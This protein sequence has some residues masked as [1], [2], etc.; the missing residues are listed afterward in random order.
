MKTKAKA[1]CR[2]V[3]VRQAKTVK[4][5][6]CKNFSSL[7]KC[8][9]H[10]THHFSIDVCNSCHREMIALQ[11]KQQGVA[12]MVDRDFELSSID[13]HLKG[14]WN[15]RMIREWASKHVDPFSPEMVESGSLD[16]RLSNLIRLPNPAWKYIKSRFF[17]L[18]FMSYAK[19]VA[20]VEDALKENAI[21]LDEQE[22]TKFILWPDDFVLLSSVERMELLPHM[23]GLLVLKST[24]G[25]LG[26]NHSH[27]GHGDPGFGFG[28]PSSWTFEV[29]N[30]GHAPYILEAGKSIIQLRIDSMAEVPMVNYADK[31]H[32]YNGQVVPTGARV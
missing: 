9:G 20:Y 4:P 28:D 30:I 12:S 11:S 31:E 27:S 29:K 8:Q 25:R 13:T 16:L 32:N 17:K 22:F 6:R 24:P 15:D 10:V 14:V 7:G 19:Q 23:T 5:R 26:L 2:A 21:W 3:I 1:G 18:S